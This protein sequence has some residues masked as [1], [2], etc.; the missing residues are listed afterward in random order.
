L[1]RGDDDHLGQR[2]WSDDRPSF[3]R[4]CERINAS[5]G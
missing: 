3:Q 1:V 4:K 5:R 2:R